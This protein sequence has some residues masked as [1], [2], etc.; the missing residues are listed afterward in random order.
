MAANHGFGEVLRTVRKQAQMSQSELARLAG[1]HASHLN[2]VERGLRGSPRRKTVERLG[3]ALLLGPEEM[4]ELLASAGYA[5]ERQELPTGMFAAPPIG[6]KH[7]GKIK[8]GRPKTRFAEA[9]ARLVLETLS[10]PDI[11]EH[12][13]RT[14]ARQIRSFTEWVAS[15]SRRRIQTAGPVPQSEAEDSR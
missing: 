11:P 12:E 3:R 7:S 10:A 8:T 15:E 2:R 4:G 5:P 1:L 6:L 9:A 14:I 13:R